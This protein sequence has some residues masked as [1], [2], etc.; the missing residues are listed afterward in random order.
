MHGSDYSGE[1][2]AGW[3]GQ[4]KWNGVF[5]GWDG[6]RLWTREGNV[7]PA[8]EFFTQGLP[9]FPLVCELTDEKEGANFANGLIKQ[10]GNPG[11]WEKAL[12]HIFDAPHAEGGGVRE[13]LAAAFHENG[14]L[15]AFDVDCFV[16]KSRADLG[17]QLRG[18]LA[19]GYEGLM[20]QPAHNPY[21]AGRTRRLLK[22]TRASLHFFQST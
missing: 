10:K 2:C 1:E 16:V 7:I 8:P 18:A 12:L 4:R 20:I 21:V 22:V 14:C 6:E 13:R 19:L 3:V 9:D 15:Y 5:A 11:R 17:V